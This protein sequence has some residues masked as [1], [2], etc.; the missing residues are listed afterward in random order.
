MFRFFITLFSAITI[1]YAAYRMKIPGGFMVG[2]VLG[3]A[4]LSITTGIA[5]MPGWS[6]VAAQVTAG[7]FIGCSIRKSDLAG[8][9][10]LLRPILTL[11]SMMLMLNLTMG[12]LVYRFSPL[13]AVTAFM[14]AVPGGMS[15]IPIIAAEMGADAA[16]VTAVQFLRMVAGIAIFP[17]VIRAVTRGEP[18]PQPQ[19]DPP[20]NTEM[21][22]SNTPRQSVVLTLLVATAGGLL[23]RA[24]G[25]PAGTLAFAVIASVLFHLTTGRA[26]LPMW[27]K[28]MAQVLSGAYIGSSISAP[29]LSEMRQVLVPALLI[30]AGYAINCFLT[31]LL[32]HR[33]CHFT[34]REGM[35]AA[36]PA[37]ASDMA[38]ISA[39]L[40]VTSPNLVVMQTLRLL[41]VVIIF[42]QVIHFVLLFLH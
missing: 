39:D 32:L 12:Y 31:G 40:G 33:G 36:T 35:L 38:L 17:S 37:G 15:D 26:V 41:A 30:L 20:A 9:R 28:R 27:A 6:K 1:G 19:T 22:V 5:Y 7:A 34:R 18:Q 11:L 42:P 23:G 29:D 8:F 3:S 10:S 2:A 4:V 16:K 24:L 14:C 13:D 21:C 25:V